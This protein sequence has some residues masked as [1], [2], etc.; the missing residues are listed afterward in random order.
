MPT[1]NITL[2]TTTTAVEAVVVLGMLSDPSRLR[3]YRSKARFPQ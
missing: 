2:F 3:P 1:L